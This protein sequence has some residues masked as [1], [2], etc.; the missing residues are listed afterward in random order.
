LP[1]SH[2]PIDPMS[3]VERRRHHARRF[4]EG[5]GHGMV[6]ARRNEERGSRGEGIACGPPGPP[7]AFRGHG[8]CAEERGTRIEGRGDCLRTSWSALRIFAF[9]GHRARGEERGTRIE[10]RGDCLRSSWS[11]LRIS[12]ASCPRGGTRIEGR[13]D[14][15]RTSWSD[16]APRPKS[17]RRTA[18]AADLAAFTRSGKRVLTMSLIHYS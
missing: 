16:H 10:G 12:R 14:C 2:N 15:L 3:V 8:A 1:Q 17:N 18:I 9:R 4:C 11:A 7:C 5:G 6:P 13:G